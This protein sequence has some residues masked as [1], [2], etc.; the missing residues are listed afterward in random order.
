MK[1]LYNGRIR[2]ASPSRNPHQETSLFSSVGGISTCTR[3]SEPAAGL[4]LATRRNLFFGTGVA[5]SREI[6]VR[7]I[8]VRRV[9]N[10]EIS[11]GAVDVALFATNS[12]T[13]TMSR[14]V[15]GGILSVAGPGN[16]IPSRCLRSKRDLIVRGGAAAD[17]RSAEEAVIGARSACSAREDVSDRY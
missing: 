16:H 12:G 11:S 13:G 6:C 10:T 3:S 9:G 7:R 2:T 14:P 1:C 15:E 8:A 17:L 4:R 5:S